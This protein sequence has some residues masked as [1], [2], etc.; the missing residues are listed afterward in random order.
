MAENLAFVYTISSL[1]YENEKYC[2]VTKSSRGCSLRNKNF[3]GM[4]ML[5]STAIEIYI[6]IYI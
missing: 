3:M 4:L 2:D 1:A 6:Y 5:G